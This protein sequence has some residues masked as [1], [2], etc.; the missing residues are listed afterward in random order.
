MQISSIVALLN[1]NE[2][3]NHNTLSEK[4][5]RLIL[6]IKKGTDKDVSKATAKDV[7]NVIYTMA[8][9]YEFYGAYTQFVNELLIAV[10]NLNNTMVK[11]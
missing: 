8:T 1:V 3:G 5:D 10:V 6:K 11:A 7:A 2:L 4:A 9:A